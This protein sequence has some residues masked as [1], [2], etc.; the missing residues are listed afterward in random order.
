MGHH[1]ERH[2][3]SLYYEML[4]FSPLVGVLGH[5]QV[6]KTTFL[7]RWATRYLTFDDQ[8][9]LQQA[10]E[11]PKLFID[12]LA[13]HH[14]VI[15][16]SQLV[17]GIFPALKERVRKSKVPGQVVLS[18]SVRFTSK[19]SIR[20][21]LTGRIQYLDLLPFSI[22]ELAEDP[23]RKNLIQALAD[24]DVTQ[25]QHRL[26]LPTTELNLR[27]KQIEMYLKNG[28]LPGVC[29]I[30]KDSL[31]HDKVADQLKTIL[32]RDLRQV[33]RSKLSFDEL[34]GFLSE[35]A[36]MEGRP[37]DYQH[38]KRKTGLNPV[39]QK[40]LLNAFESIFLIRK[41]PILGDVQ[42]FTYI[43]EDQAESYDLTEGRL[44]R[45]QQLMSLLYRNL[46]TETFY[47]SG[48]KIQEFQFRKRSGGVVPIAFK[49]LDSVVGFL[50]SDDSDPDRKTLG[51]AGTFLKHFPNAKVVI[52]N[53]K[54]VARTHS[55]RIA[56]SPLAG[57][58]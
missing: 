7:E 52:L 24:R 53:E 26:S 18:G 9:V 1:R 50:M 49:T 33:Y 3:K 5:R 16:E 11:N 38:F 29:F 47:R 44:L 40:N 12:S 39:T 27:T 41:V 35:V 46:R 48:A 31:R 20:E 51:I 45:S 30:R 8:Q 58:V 42:S 43:L 19:A 28:G 34:K 22:S 14:T 6:G 32:D 37:C 56:I 57:W 10:R 13:G 17:E 23:L 54:G 36:M 21:S 55:P 15:D 25:L 4:A 2:I